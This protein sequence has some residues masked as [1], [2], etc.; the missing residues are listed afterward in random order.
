M[1]A[2]ILSYIPVCAIE[3][4]S[5]GWSLIMCTELVIT[6]QQHH[7]SDCKH[8]YSHSEHVSIPFVP[9]LCIE[10]QYLQAFGTSHAARFRNGDDEK[11]NCIARILG[12]R[13]DEEYPKRRLRFRTVYHHIH[14][15]TAQRYRISIP[16][17]SANK[18]KQHTQTYYGFNT[19]SYL[20]HFI[21]K[22]E[23]IRI[24]AR[25]IGIQ[26]WCWEKAENCSH[27]NRLGRTRWSRKSN[28]LACFQTTLSCY[29]SS[30]NLFLGV[31]FHFYSIHDY[32]L[33]Q[34]STLGSSIYTPAFPTIEKDFHVSSTVALLPLTFY[35]LALGLGPLLA[36]PMSET[37]G[38][39]IVYIVSVPLGALFTMGTGFSQDIW[40]LCILRFFSGLAFSPALAIG[41]GSI[42]DVNRP[43]HRA[44]PSALYILSPFLGPA[45]GLVQLFRVQW[46]CDWRLSD[47][48]SALLSQFVNLG[49]G[50]NGPSS[51]SPSSHSLLPCSP[52]RPTRKSSSLV[53]PDAWTSL[54]HHRLSPQH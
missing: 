42:A 14:C 38:R 19:R 11:L 35:V 34:S 29:T 18:H 2:D 53:E 47:Q 49:D 12:I 5:N 30:Y 44:V 46:N 41:A 23:D 17:S 50:H 54:S 9:S 16:A 20:H 37:Y 13:A 43:E 31:S 21:G 25:C 32:I 28:E 45:L 8:L 51:S 48:W 7:K 52:K 6:K 1:F 3:P 26:R 10:G 24:R 40:T 39:H 22:W 36:A 27:C 33:T 4:S 15:L